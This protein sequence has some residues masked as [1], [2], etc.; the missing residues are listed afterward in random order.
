M[1]HFHEGRQLSVL[2]VGLFVWT[3]SL[4]T[5]QPTVMG[6]LKKSDTLNLLCLSKKCPNPLPWQLNVERTL[7]Q[8]QH[9][10]QATLLSHLQ[11]C[12]EQHSESP[13]SANSYDCLWCL[14]CKQG[15]AELLRVQSQTGQEDLKQR[16]RA[17]HASVIWRRTTSTHISLYHA[18]AYVNKR[19][20]S[21]R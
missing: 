12:K 9:Y 20:K 5:R 17:A 6:S 7:T 8:W 21:F 16:Q 14:I 1:L 11:L 4:H 13:L 10:T 18:G 19:K 3:L 15:H 2:D